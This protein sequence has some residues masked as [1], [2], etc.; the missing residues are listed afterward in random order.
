MCCSR[1]KYYA[2][3]DA[4]FYAKEFLCRAFSSTASDSDSTL[5]KRSRNKTLEDVIDAV[6]EATRASDFRPVSIRLSAICCFQAS[7]H[8][9]QYPLYRPVVELHHHVFLLAAR[10]FMTIC[11]A[12]DR[13]VGCIQG[14]RSTQF[15]ICSSE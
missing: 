7:T 12:G 1:C 6:R 9:P 3:K 10:P 5:K 11:T 15:R 8:A 13:R 2:G 14:P 4:G